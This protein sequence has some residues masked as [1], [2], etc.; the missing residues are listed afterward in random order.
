MRD[1]APGIELTEGLRLV[2]ALGRGAM[3]EVWVA[4]S[5]TE[6]QVA[7][8]FLASNVRHDKSAVRRFEREWV[9]ASKIRSPHVVRMLN[10]GHTSD[11]RPYI[12]MELLAGQSLEALLE[13]VGTL[14][15]AAAIVL[16][17]QVANALDAAHAHGIVHRDI[18]PENILL[19]VIGRKTVVKVLDF[20]LA[21]PWGVR[22]HSLTQTGVLMGTPYF[23]SPE[24]LVKGGKDIDGRADLWALAAV[25]Y[26]V[27]LG[28]QPF[29]ADS[30][31]ALVFEVLKGSYQSMTEVGGSQKLDPF[32]QRAFSV[33]R[34]ARFSTAREL[35]EDL[36]RR[37]EIDSRG[38]ASTLALV[39]E[40]PSTRD[41]ARD[42][43]VPTTTTRVAAQPDTLSTTQP[44]PAAEEAADADAVAGAGATAFAGAPGNEELAD[45][46][47]VLERGPDSITEM[48]A[49]DVPIPRSVT[50]DANQLESQT[51]L[52]RLAP[53]RPAATLVARDVPPRAADETPT[54]EAHNDQQHPVEAKTLV[55]DVAQTTTQGVRA[56]AHHAEAHHAEAHHAEAHHAEAHHAEAHHVSE[57]PVARL[58]HPSVAASAP[59]L[60]S[61]RPPP[62]FDVQSS[63]FPPAPKGPS[64]SPKARRSLILAL[65]ATLTA[66]VI[67]GF[68]GWRQFTHARAPV[69]VSG[70]DLNP[71]VHRTPS[72]GMS[73]KSQPAPSRPTSKTASP[74]SAKAASRSSA[75]VP[76]EVATA[77]SETT[78]G[79]S[80]APSSA[81]T[82]AEAAASRISYLTVTCKPVCIVF[83]DGKRIGVS[84]VR[85]QAFGAG[86]HR[87]VAYRD[88]LGGKVQTIKLAPGQ[89][90][91]TNV[92]M[93]AK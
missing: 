47:R 86:S 91:T 35:V 43:T 3:G 31:H 88:D 55:P 8:K 87:V 33:D 45:E 85:K 22:G 81:S 56:E 28:T 2:R 53:P 16:L 36:N 34:E 14:P 84:P 30:L 39:D 62:R 89:H 10:L 60:P 44:I 73:A 90:V 82:D 12:V 9:M 71:T 78:P 66:I 64:P 57:A 79:G 48:R 17:R 59:T 13:Q 29:D 20:G 93:R 41:Y 75:D 51:K 40:A 4:D 83:V 69:A 1:P 27:L 49:L 80:A 42:N 7:V 50:A 68:V 67:V 65:G 25:A 6:G 46:E 76:P 74:P 11:G 58:S 77:R 70:D 61:N 18:K 92:N 24:Q 21:K 19:C 52:R 5:T 23:M 63:E 26:R 38:E 37:L 72:D 15:P 32:F 54:S